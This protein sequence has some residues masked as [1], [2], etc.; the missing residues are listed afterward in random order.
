MSSTPINMEPNRGANRKT[1]LG[2]MFIGGRAN[3]RI[4]LLLASLVV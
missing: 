2:S 1:I 3:L 4:L